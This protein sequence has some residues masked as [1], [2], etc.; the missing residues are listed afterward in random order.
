MFVINVEGAV[1]RKGKW[2]LIE[3]SDEEEHAG[4]LLAFVGGTVDPIAQS[5]H[6]LEQ[7][8]KREMFEEVGLTIHSEMTYVR[9]SSFT[10][11]DGRHVVNIVFLCSCEGD[12]EPYIKSAEEVKGIYWL[13]TDEVLAHKNAP[14][15]LKESMGDLSSLL[16]SK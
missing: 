9:N 8:L 15:W 10:L 2:L 1:L 14:I 12:S 7:T 13:T 16:A 6:L 4:G 11:P 5:T 3:R